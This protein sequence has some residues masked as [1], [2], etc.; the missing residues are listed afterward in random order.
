RDPT[1]AQTCASPPRASAPPPTR[2]DGSGTHQTGTGVPPH[3]DPGGTGNSGHTGTRGG[4][5]SAPFLGCGGERPL[6]IGIRR[7]CQ[8]G[9]ALLRDVACGEFSE[10]TREEIG[11][12]FGLAG[13]AALP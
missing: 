13:H 7:L 6:R 3:A 4:S 1:G 12:T 9:G 8:V 10:H 2:W 5:S 11:K